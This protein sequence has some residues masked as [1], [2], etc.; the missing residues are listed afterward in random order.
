MRDTPEPAPGGASQG[1]KTAQ[2]DCAL[3]DNAPVIVRWKLPFS[4]GELQDM[5]AAMLAAAGRPDAQ[6]ELVVLDDAS[7]EVLH[8]Q[9]LGRSGPTNIL[10]FPLGAGRGGASGSLLGALAL[11]PDTFLRE[12]FLY[13][14]DPGEHCARLLAHGLA[15]LLGLEHGPEMERMEALM[16]KAAAGR[17]SG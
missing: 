11:S 17:I 2:E 10:S 4:S 15:H 9:C 8:G 14:Q 6:A 1:G 5:I 7:M 16:E 3:P 13:G 12:C